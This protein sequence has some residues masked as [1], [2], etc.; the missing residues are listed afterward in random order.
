MPKSGRLVRKGN[1]IVEDFRNPPKSQVAGY[2]RIR[3]KRQSRHL[4]TVAIL[5]NGK[6]RVTSVWHPLDER[7]SANQRV[8]RALSASRRRK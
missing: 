3:P 4:I 7:R 8:Q 2:R 6:T 1:H 5:R